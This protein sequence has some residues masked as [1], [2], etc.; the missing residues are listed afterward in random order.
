MKDISGRSGSGSSRSADLTR[1]LES[2][3]RAKVASAGSTLFRLTWKDRVTPLGR[4]IPS[5]LG[6]ALL[7]CEA[8]C[9]SWATPVKGDNF[10]NKYLDGN[11]DGRIGNQ[12]RLVR[13]PWPTPQAR[14]WKGPQGRAYGNEAADLPSVAVWV[15]GVEERLPK[16]KVFGKVVNGFP[17]VTAK[18]VQLNPALSRWLMGLPPAW[19]DCGVTAMHSAPRT[20]RASSKRS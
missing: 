5:L 18:G 15:E 13:R 19:D 8:V 20:Q 9:T 4:V 12:A 6:S 2:R 14:D 3:L 17:S 10:N 11:G 16:G 7:T 1:S